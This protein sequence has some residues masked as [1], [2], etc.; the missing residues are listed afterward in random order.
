M[1]RSVLLIFFL[2]G[3]GATMAQDVE[4]IKY[5]QLGAIINTKEDGIKV[6]NFWATWCKPCVEEIGYFE[7]ANSQF[8]DKGVSVILV[9]FDFGKDVEKKVQKFVD[10]ND[11]H[12]RVLLLDETD[13]NS[14]ID[15]VSPS[16]SGAIPA[17][18]IVN[19][20]TGK[21]QFYEKTFKEGELSEVIEAFMN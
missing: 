3:A 12:S 17:T 1:L 9:S 5:P 20:K 4:V 14:F 10:K 2:F 13:Y 19:S 7:A 16:W 11:L 15:K 18:L 8:R 6:I 21:K